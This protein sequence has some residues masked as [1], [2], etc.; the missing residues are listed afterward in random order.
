MITVTV[1]SS[2]ITTSLAVPLVAGGLFTLDKV[3]PFLLGANIG[4]TI[5]A[6][7]GALS[8][9]GSAHA[10][11][12]LSVALVHLCFNLTGTALWIWHPAKQVPIYLARKLA[13]AVVRFR[14]LASR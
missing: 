6:L 4:T 7:I 11:E 14:I 8:L 2:S 3:Y 9:A 10:Q 5:T 13:S 1:Q 12:A